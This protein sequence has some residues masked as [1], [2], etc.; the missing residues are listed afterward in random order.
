MD[1]ESKEQQHAFNFPFQV[2]TNG[3]N[4]MNG[5]SNAHNVANGDILIVGSDG[6]WDNLHKSSV[7]DIVNPFLKAGPKIEN[8]TLVAELIAQEAERQSYLQ[9]SM[10]PFAQSA[11]EHNYHYRGGKPDDIT[12]VVAQIQ[13]K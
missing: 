4:P 13:L 2:G 9:N 8:P 5:E 11:K 10:S 6:L 3:D 7:L 1:F 12:V